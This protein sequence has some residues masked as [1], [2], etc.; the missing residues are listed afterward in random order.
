[1][2]QYNM[3]DT[4]WEDSRAMATFIYN[5]VPPSTRIEGE[6]WISP[7]QKQY[8]KRVSMDMSKIKPFGLTCY[9]FQKKERR[10]VGYHGKSDKKEHAKKGVLIGYDDQKGTLLVKVYYPKENTYAWVDEQLVTYA[11]P[12]LALDKVR[13][14]K[15]LVLPKE[16]PVSY[17][18]PLIGTRHTDPEN[19]LLYETVEV[20]MNREGYIVAFRKVVT[21][22]KVTG[23]K[24]GPIH[25]A[26]I[27]RYTDVDLDY[28]SSLVGGVQLNTAPSG[29]DEGGRTEVDSTMGGNDDGELYTSPGLHG[30]DNSSSSRGSTTHDVIA[31]S[32]SNPKKRKREMVSSEQQPV[33]VRPRRT[34]VPIERL[35]A[36][37]NKRKHRQAHMT[38]A[39]AAA[40][41]SGDMFTMLAVD[42]IQK[43]GT[44]K[45]T[46][47]HLR[48]PDFEPANRKQMLET[49]YVNKW[50]A[51]E[52]EELASIKKN[53]VWHK[54]PPP[55]GTKVLP[56][57]WIYKVKKD[58]MGTVV[59]NKCRLVAQGFFQV[60][61]EDYDQTYSP[62]AKFTSIRTLLAMSAQLG[63]TVRQMDVDT[64]FLNAPIDEHIWYNF[65]KVPDLAARKTMASTN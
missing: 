19:G 51:G 64:A 46:A 49:K 14:G 23:Y 1:M 8:P 2:I 48:R 40:V 31:D 57:K 56:L 9:V 38:T 30:P 58:R 54:V 11:D 28:L 63:L 55:P 34:T 60:F 4:Y 18:E 36:D 13:K 29:E 42:Q 59:R 15:V 10:N 3:D 25:V 17:F 39:L 20:K 12:L 7:L 65:R 50:I 32:N 35:S 41:A 24:D 27:A 47:E 26:D 5:R 37:E 53:D 52:K 22:G 21:R 6:P 62:V 43:E 16:V 45:P 61:G 44:T 33:T